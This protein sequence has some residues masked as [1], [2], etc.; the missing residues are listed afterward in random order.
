MA[1]PSK[2]ADQ[3]NE[4]LYAVFGIDRVEAIQGNHCSLAGCT[5]PCEEL[6]FNNDI[7]RREYLIS[8]LCQKHQDEVFA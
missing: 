2:K 4:S 3:I 5:N 8:G 1:T 7:N 6:D